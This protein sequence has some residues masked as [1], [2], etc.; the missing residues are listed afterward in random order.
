[1]NATGFVKFEVSGT[2]NYTLYEEVVGGKVVLEDVLTVGDY[3]VVVTYLGDGEFNSNSTVKSFTIA[4][5]VKKDTSISAVPKVDN[6]TVKTLL[7]LLKV[8]KL[9]S[10]MTS[11]QQPTLQM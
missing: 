8:V 9:F 1:M 4:G 6:Y 11:N 10:H 3:M 7:F 5:H 2:E